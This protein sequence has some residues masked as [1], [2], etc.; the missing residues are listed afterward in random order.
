MRRAVGDQTVW[1][2]PAGEQVTLPVVLDVVQVSSSG[3][4][5]WLIEATVDMVDGTPAITSISVVSS[6]G[7]DTD[8]LQNDFRWAT[9]LDVVTITVPQLLA[10][11]LD[12]YEHDYATRGYP[13]AAEVSRAAHRQL[14]D[15][16]LAEV[17]RR[18]LA[19]GRGYA[20]A[21]ALQYQVSPRTVVSWV[22]KARAR[23]ILSSTKPGVAGGNLHIPMGQ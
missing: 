17:S 7:L 5:E 18:Y 12:P 6:S 23:G 4:T 20:A 16:F 11:G 13:D 1:T 15:A 22:E 9:P 8:R 10:R 14:S 2:A 3:D 21:L 19:H